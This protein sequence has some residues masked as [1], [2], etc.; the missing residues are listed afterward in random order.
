MKRPIRRPQ[1][2]DP[3]E[4]YIHQVSNSP[5]TDTAR[6]PSN[7]LDSGYSSQLEKSATSVSM[8]QMNLGQSAKRH[9]A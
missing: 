1:I 6:L 3:V 4:W 7:Y 8:G 2:P 5:Q 9:I